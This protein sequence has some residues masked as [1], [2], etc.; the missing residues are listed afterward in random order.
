MAK[1]PATTELIKIAKLDFDPTV[2]TRPPKQAK[3]DKYAQHFD[4]AALGVI[5]V[6][7]RP[8]GRFVVLDGQHRVTMLRDK[9]G[10]NNGQEI[11]CRVHRGLSHAD[12]CALF[13]ML[14][15]ETPVSS[16]HKLMGG[17][18]AGIEPDVSIGAI[19]DSVGLKVADQSVDGNVAAATALRYVWGGCIGGASGRK[20][21]DGE[22]HPDLLRSTLR[23]LLAA[24]GTN[25]DAYRGDVLSGAGLFL[26]RHGDNPKLDLESLTRKLSLYEGGPSAFVGEARSLRKLMRCE[27]RTA[28]AGLMVNL[29]NQQR[30]SS[31]LPGWWS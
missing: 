13:V 19:V 2:N 17:I 29:Y 4:P 18:G 10:W 16:I 24:W 12:E 6:S 20:W 5:E 9:L 31:K 1:N 23:L 3:I 21:R 15:D 7:A 22:S 8:R 25:R 11:L 28:V 14:N 30:R 26:A 27:V